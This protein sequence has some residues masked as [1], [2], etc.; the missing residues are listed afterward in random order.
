MTDSRLRALAKTVMRDSLLLAPGERVLIDIWDGAED[1][2]CCLVQAAYEAEA[3]PFVLL[4]SSR[5]NRALYQG[6]SEESM[7]DWLR[8][9]QVR[10]EA[11]D[12]YVVVRKQDNIYAYSDVPPRQMERF[13]RYY[14]RLHNQIRIPNTKWCVLRY[15]NDAMAQLAAMSTEAFEDYYFNACCLDYV[16]MRELIGPLR[17]YLAEA[18]EVRILGPGTDL[19]FSIKGMCA[20]VS[21]CGR[22]NLPCG[23]V[24][25]PVHP[26]SANGSIA[27]NVPSCYQGRVFRDIRF[28][29]KEGV[30]TEARA[31][32]SEGL[33]QILD[34]D[35]GARRIGE[36]AMGLNPFITRPAMDTL[37]DE[38]MAL[39]LHFTPGHSNVNPSAIHWDLVTS[40]AAE[41]GGGRIWVDGKLLRRDGLFVGEFEALNP[42]NLKKE[43]GPRPM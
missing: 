43:V 21:T 41:L 30:I 7:A 32:D 9:E 40:H 34:T 25:M 38:K 37:F 39:S 6:A 20:P 28:V 31:D 12:A 19:V 27:Y 16:R 1:F 18:D 33:N 3:L 35:A 8:F 5:V 24:G 42:D 11:M 15:P 10:M 36:F 29:L 17:A 22:W 23:E 2:A 14:G 26:D 13:S 4:Q